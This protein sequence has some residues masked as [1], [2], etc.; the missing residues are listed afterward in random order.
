MARRFA[1]GVGAIFF[2]L[3]AAGV[4]FAGPLTARPGHVAPVASEL[5]SALLD[6]VG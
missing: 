4:L 6:L 1:L 5:L 2:I 3:A